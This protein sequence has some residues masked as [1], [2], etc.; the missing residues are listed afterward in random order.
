[1]PHAISLFH[2]SFLF[3]VFGTSSLSPAHPTCALFLLCPLLC[4]PELIPIFCC[5]ISVPRLS[6]SLSLVLPCCPISISYA[7]LSIPPSLTPTV[8][9]LY[10]LSLS[11][12]S[13]LFPSVPSWSPSCLSLIFAPCNTLVS[14]L[15]P[16]PQSVPSLLLTCPSSKSLSL[17]LLPVPHPVGPLS[18]LHPCQLPA[19]CPSQ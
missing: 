12:T 7:L 16:L 6:P 4:F 5:P 1:M 17:S 19:V 15:F 3:W 11:I 18:A 8:F 14:L 13:T 2:P 10:T 9:H